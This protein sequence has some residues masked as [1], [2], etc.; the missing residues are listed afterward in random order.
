MK[1]KIKHEEFIKEMFIPG[2]K[3]IPE[4]RKTVEIEI[5]GETVEAVE[6]AVQRISKVLNISKE[7]KES[8]ETDGL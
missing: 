8:E 5:E 1:I 3:P 4:N 7:G 6:N 2:C